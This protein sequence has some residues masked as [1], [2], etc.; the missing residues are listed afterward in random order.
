MTALTI[1]LNPV[2][3]LTD[4]QFYHLCRVNPDVKFERNTERELIIM[5]PTGGETGKRNAGITA[6]FVIWNRQTRLGEVFDS[7]TCFRLPN[8][9]DRSPDVAWIQK[10][11]WD[12]LTSEQKEKFPPIAPDFVLELMS[13]TDNLKETQAKMREYMDNQVRLGWL[14]NRKSQRVEIYRQGKPVEVLENPTELSGEDVL[15]GFVL[16]LRI[17]WE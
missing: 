17:V 13:P 10:E 4:E 6:D 14:M 2:I 3:Q 11:R 9:A 5:S 1:N 8:G 12:G 15:P 7:S 16:D